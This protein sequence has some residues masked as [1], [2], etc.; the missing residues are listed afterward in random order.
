MRFSPRLQNSFCTLNSSKSK[1]LTPSV[2]GLQDGGVVL[3]VGTGAELVVSGGV[4]LTAQ[5]SQIL[6]HWCLLQPTLTP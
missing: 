5:S 4:L 2:A 6:L 3:E 1:T